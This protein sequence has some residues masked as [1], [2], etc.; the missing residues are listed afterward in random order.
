MNKTL[1]YTRADGY[2]FYYNGSLTVNV[3]RDGKN[4]SCFTLGW[5]HDQYSMSDIVDEMDE[6]SIYSDED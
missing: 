4:I 3:Y 1:S 5:P 2:D 6:W